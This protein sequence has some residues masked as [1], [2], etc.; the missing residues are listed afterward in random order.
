MTFSELRGSLPQIIAVSIKNI[1][2]V[3]FGMTIGFPT[4]LIPALQQTTERK[5]SSDLSLNNS[6]ISWISSINL[7]CVPLG[8]IFS[9]TFTYYLGRRR[10]MQIVCIPIFI[11]WIII[12]YAKDVAHL[13]IAL[14]LSGFTGGILEAPVLTYVAEITTPKL[15]GILAATGSFCII[16]GVFSQFLMGLYFDWKTITIFSTFAPLLAIVLLFFVPESPHWL[17]LKKRDEEAKLSL[18]WLRGWH[19]SY[20]NVKKEFEELHS[21]LIMQA[22]SKE[23]AIQELLKAFMKRTFFLPFFICTLGFFV[24][25]FSGMTT[26]QTYAV[27]IFAE[28]KVPIDKYFATMLL[29]IMEL[30]G[31]AIC[32]ILVRFVGKR[33]LTF[34]SLLGCSICFFSTAMYAFFINYSPSQFQANTL[35]INL[36]MNIENSTEN[37]P[38]AIETF[39]HLAVDEEHFSYLHLSPDDVN[40]TSSIITDLN[41]KTSSSIS[42]IPLTLLLGSALLSHSGI[43]LLPWMLVGEVYPAKIRGLASGFTGGFSYIFGFLANKL[44]L[45]MV[46]SFTLPGTFLFYSCVGCSGCL[47]LYLILPE[48]EGRTL[49]EI[50][51][52]FRGYHKLPK[53]IKHNQPTQGNANNFNHERWNINRKF[54]ERHKSTEN[55]FQTANDNDFIDTYI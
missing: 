25:N 42:W 39:S 20:E 13:Y 27:P 26:L 40:K 50:E 54:E 3:G 10:A 29:G 47:I 48:T 43:R 7:I 41:S 37:S 11:S 2:L 8:C 32:V 46:A 14:C 9:G 34:V 4:V 45:T 33:K 49:Q 17:I 16:L 53:T 21:C 36:P 30:L 44:F 55:N 35:V 24:G 51:E 31:T 38:R 52:Y 23:K 22:H 15:R 18:M 1:I 28:L 12:Y 6:Q 5:P 19:K